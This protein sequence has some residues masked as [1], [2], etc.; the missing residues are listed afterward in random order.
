MSTPEESM[1]PNISGAPEPPV[2]TPQPIP[3][4]VLASVKPPE[5]PPDPEEEPE[6][7]PDAPEPPT[8]VEL[9]GTREAPLYALLKKPEELTGRDAALA[10]AGTE[11]GG[12]WGFADALIPRLVKS[13]NLVTEKGRPI[14]LPSVNPAWYDQIPPK[15]WMAL[16]IAALEFAPTIFPDAEFLRKDDD[17]DSPTSA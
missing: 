9:G 5:D 4:N 16:A 3:A 15:A 14:K 12:R 2:Y 10:M 11:S 7:V 17:P 1:P 13:W 8:R 6:P